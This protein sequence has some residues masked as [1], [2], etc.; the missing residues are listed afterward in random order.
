[1]DSIGGTARISLRLDPLLVGGQPCPCLLFGGQVSY[2]MFL[3]LVLQ[4][5]HLYPRA[6]FRF[7]LQACQSVTGTFESRA[8]LWGNFWEGRI[9]PGKARS[10]ETT[11]RKGSLADNYC[12][13][14]H[15]RG[16]W[17]RWTRLTSLS[18]GLRTAWTGW[19]SKWESWKMRWDQCRFGTDADAQL[20]RD[21]F[22]CWCWLFLSCLAVTT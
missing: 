5:R 12:N 22:W 21:F 18:T 13:L 20:V 6:N 1:M 9:W 3:R 7:D 15:S 2:L 17:R 11:A 14:C 10:M 19:S 4:Q 16:S 8:A